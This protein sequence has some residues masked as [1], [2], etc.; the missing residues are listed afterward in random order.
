MKAKD[1]AVVYTDLDSMIG[2]WK[3]DPEFDKVIQEQDSI[4]LP[5]TIVPPPP[6]RQV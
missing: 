5:P 6:H 2:T 1:D 3:D 4:Q